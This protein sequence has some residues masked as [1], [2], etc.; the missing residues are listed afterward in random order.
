[1]GNERRAYV[2]SA[3]SRVF[4]QGIFLAIFAV[5]LILSF[6]G[7]M[8]DNEGDFTNVRLNVSRGRT[9][10]D[11]FN[12]PLVDP[13]I[14]PMVAV[15]IIVTAPDLDPLYYNFGPADVTANAGLLELLVPSG[16]ARTFNVDLF[17]I[18]PQLADTFPGRAYDVTT[19]PEAR[20]VD[21]AG[22]PVVLDI[23]MQ[24]SSAVTIWGVV[25][26]TRTGVMAP[27]MPCANPNVAVS[28]HYQKF[29]TWLIPISVAPDGS[30][31]ISN[32]PVNK[33]FIYE[34]VDFTTNASETS[35]VFV[36]DTDVT[37][38][39]YLNGASP[40]EII[41][42]SASVDPGEAV[43]FM[44]AHGAPPYTFALQANNSGCN[45][46]PDGT[47]TAGGTRKVTDVVMVTDQC[48]VGPADTY[49]IATANVYVKD[50]VPE[51]NM[52]PS[53]TSMAPLTATEDILYTYNA[54]VTDPD[55]PPQML[56][57]SVN[58]LDTC[59][60]SLIGC[61]Y[62]VTPG[63][64]F[65]GTLCVVGL[66]VTDD[67]VPPMYA[68]QETTVTITEVNQ[69]PAVPTVTCGS[70]GEDAATTCAIS[71]VSDTDIPLQILSCSVGAA[72]TCTGVTLTG[73]ATVDVPAQGEAAGPGSCIVAVTVSDDFTPAGTATGQGTLTIN[74]VNQNP[75][76]TTAPM[77]TIGI[78]KNRSYNSVN[79][80]ASDS[81]LPNIMVGDPG[82]LSCGIQN[83]TCSFSVM[84]TDMGSGVVS[85]NISFTA[86]TSAEACGFDVVV[87]DGYAG[88]VS[89]NV[90]VN[91]ADRW[92]VDDTATGLNNG[93][94]WTNAYT[95]VQAAVDAAMSG[96]EVWV[97]QGTYSTGTTTPVVTMKDGVLIY[98]GFQGTENLLSERT[99]PTAFPA[100]LDGITTS[101]PV[102][103]A[104]S[105][106]SLDGFN[107][108]GGS[109][110][111]YGAGIQAINLS[112]FTLSKCQV[113]GNSSSYGGSGML[114]RD[115]TNTRVLNSIFQNNTGTG[116]DFGAG[117][118]QWGGSATI[119]NCLFYA[120]NNVSY[121]GG[122]V[123]VY[124]TY[125]PYTMIENSAFTGNNNGGG[126]GGA[127]ATLNSQSTITNSILWA[128][129]G[130]SEIAEFSPPSSTV[131]SYSDVQG[132]YTGTGNINIDPQ[133]IGGGNYHVKPSSPVIDTGDPASTLT[134]DL[135]SLPRPVGGAVDM[136][137]YEWKADWY[138]DA[139]SAGPWT[140]LSWPEAFT[141]VQAAMD[142]ASAGDAIIVGMGTYS[143]GTTAPVLTMKAGVS[144]YG[145]FFP[146]Q[147]TLF[148]RTD[149]AAY[150][151]IL[152]GNNVSYHCVAGASN[153]ILDGFTITNGNASGD[154]GGGVYNNG[155]IT[156]FV[157]SNC[158]FNSNNAWYGG[159]IF[160]WNASGNIYK[161]VFES[162]TADWHGGAI[163]SNSDTGTVSFN[164]TNCLF[165]NNTAT[166]RDGGAI[167][168]NTNAGSFSPNITNCTFSG[169]SAQ[170]GGA[171]SN[172]PGTFP[173]IKNCILWGN[174]AAVSG[175]EINGGT[176]TVT[177]SDVQGGYAGTGNIDADPLFISGTDYHLQ[178]SS[179]C[180]DIG[181]AT[182][183]PLDDLDR[184][185]RPYNGLFDMGAYEYHP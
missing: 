49:S 116:S 106:A 125:G 123:G 135:D 11:L 132:G 19:P 129:S 44:A 52:T 86:G 62:N 143:T 28:L 72:T 169:N 157:I 67:G 155:P 75:I 170:N 46:T 1:M 88:Y 161:C 91:V 7:C 80:V 26:D 173:D 99:D 175:N 22:N 61:N 103:Q 70:I 178:S 96:E 83:N 181:T 60:G 63:E 177:Y 176:P 128:D 87:T 164:V 17:E 113:Y 140:G 114:T 84:T 118:L 27:L 58:A 73:C 105:N 47:Y 126:G 153:A 137:P 5:A 108:T 144:I 41:P 31:S 36:A 48:Y 104:A 117:I 21:L 64:A 6:P 3:R 119:R 78:I 55:I 20:T 165:V 65:G 30:Y 146:G 148:E 51:P 74:E 120:N 159:A 95:T 79:G 35:V 82:Y 151:T 136:G 184:Y 89:G 16:N 162:N 149:P 179:P 172:W 98:G 4:S 33:S 156:G 115:S 130:G 40:I 43:F 39:F 154:Y 93:L 112:D 32:M 12:S 122:A 160:N 29:F 183:A 110:A 56:T 166:S 66:R 94:S 102:V 2:K 163:Y 182:G 141:T 152:D 167:T 168:N 109:C 138:V 38:E 150:P 90:A 15:Q 42:L 34:V 131:I 18:T 45:L 134:T 121:Y 54:T 107:V 180:K 97:A 24:A 9:S 68:D 127:L 8:N 69:N 59:G 171:F 25:N 174:T 124:Y 71:G 142:A 37:Q 81:D 92:Y 133:F 101:V 57:C 145:G 77:A 50:F 23:T 139:A 185:L 10:G 100:T 85:C 147:E 111:C 76:W 13:A 53:F 14:Y 158:I